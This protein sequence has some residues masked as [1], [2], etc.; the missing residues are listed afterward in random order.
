MAGRAAE[1]WKLI[2]LRVLHHFHHLWNIK[3]LKISLLSIT[4]AS[5][6]HHRHHSSE[7]HAALPAMF[8]FDVQIVGGGLESGE[9]GPFLLRLQGEVE[10]L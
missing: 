4:L 2:G 6:D 9:R 8:G 7:T 5:V 10:Q 1:L 3:N